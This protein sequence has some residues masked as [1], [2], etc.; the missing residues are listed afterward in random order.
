MQK[1][2]TCLRWLFSCLTLA[3]AVTASAQSQLPTDVEIHASYCIPVLQEEIKTLRR[4]LAAM[5][6]VL[7]HIDRVPPETRQALMQRALEDKRNVPEEIEARE[8]ALHKLQSFLQ[9]RTSSLETSAL[10][11]ATARANADLEQAAMRAQRCPSQCRVDENPSS[12]LKTC[13]SSDFEARVT[14]CRNPTWLL[15]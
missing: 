10:L 5:D 13:L 2:Y 14:E 6:N 15:P 4:L 3:V 8:S 7:A 12:C 9:P 1:K 11:D